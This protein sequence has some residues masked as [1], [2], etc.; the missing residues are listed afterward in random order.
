MPRPCRSCRR[1]GHSNRVEVVDCAC[2]HSSTYARHTDGSHGGRRATDPCGVEHRRAA[3][4]V[5]CST[6][7]HAKSDVVAMPAVVSKVGALSPMLVVVPKVG[8]LPL[9]PSVWPMPNR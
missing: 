2:G 3:P 8:D 5:D 9:M 6:R 4:Y 7:C 1:P